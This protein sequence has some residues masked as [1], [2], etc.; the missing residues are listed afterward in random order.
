VPYSCDEEKKR[1]KVLIYFMKYLSYYLNKEKSF[2][3]AFGFQGVGS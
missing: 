2:F 1:E 3:D